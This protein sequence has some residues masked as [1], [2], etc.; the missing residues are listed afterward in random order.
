MMRPTRCRGP[1]AWMITR[2]KGAGCRMALRFLLSGIP[3]SL[4]LRQQDGQEAAFATNT[5]ETALGGRTLSR[6]V[7]HRERPLILEILPQESVGTVLQPGGI[8]SEPPYRR[9]GTRAQGSTVL[10]A[11][12]PETLDICQHTKLLILLGSR[13]HKGRRSIAVHSAGG[14]RGSYFRRGSC[15]PQEWLRSATGCSRSFLQSDR[16]TERL[17]ACMRPNPEC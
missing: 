6:H 9:R 8:P 1:R 4:K 3:V 5:R 16:R 14:H 12:E 17:P 7:C 11:A 15:G 2:A 10:V 13:T